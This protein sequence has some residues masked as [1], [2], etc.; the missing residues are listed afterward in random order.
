M[1]INIPDFIE[2]WRKLRKDD[3]E[4]K[5]VFVAKLRMSVEFTMFRALSSEDEDLS[6]LNSLEIE[7]DV[8]TTKEDIH[9]I[10]EKLNKLRGVDFE[11]KV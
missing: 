11:N 10:I 8:A 1:S 4:A 2:S 5:A 6:L 9:Q 3:R 7:L